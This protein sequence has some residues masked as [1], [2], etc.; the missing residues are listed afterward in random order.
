M[1]DT[2]QLADQFI[3][4]SSLKGKPAVRVSSRRHWYFNITVEHSV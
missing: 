4:Q 2:T 1:P 3:Y